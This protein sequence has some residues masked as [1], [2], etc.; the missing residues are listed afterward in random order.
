MLEYQLLGPLEVRRAGEPVVLTAPKVKALL[1]QLLLRADEVVPTEHLVDALWGEEPPESARKLVQVY[2]SQLRVALGTEEIETAAAGYRLRVSSTALDARRF[3]TMREDGAR[4]LADGNPELALA[5]TRRALSLWRGS[6]LAGVAEEA[7]AAAEAWRLEELRLE[8]TEDA[9]DAE[10]ALGRHAEVIPDLRSLSSEHPLRERLRERLALALYRAGRQSEALAVL[11]EGR[12]VLLEELGLAPGRGHQDLERAILAQDPDLDVAP[13]GLSVGHLVPA[14][15]TPLVGRQDEL[16]RLRALID[17]EEVRLVTIS[18][19]GGSGKTRVALELA[20]SATDG[21]A[22]GV[23]FVELAAT[24]DP[25]L[26]LPAIA[27]GLGVPETKEQKPAEALAHWLA[28]RDLLLVV[29]NLEHVIDAAGDL[30]RLLTAAPRLTLLVTS[31][32]VLH[33]SGE[34]VFPLAPLPVDEAVRLFSERAAARDRTVGADPDTREVLVSI[35]RRLD[36]LPLA[37]ELAA[38]RT[39]TLSPTRLLERLAHRVTA[40][41][42]GPRDAPARQRTLEDTLRWSTDLLSGRER[43]ALARLSV[44]SGGSTIEAAE[45][46]SETDLECLAALI[47][48]SLVQRTALGGDVRLSMLET[49]REHAAALLGASGDRDAAEAAHAAYFTAVAEAA[50]G[51]GPLTQAATLERID[52]DLANL[53][54]AMDRAEQRGDD[55][56]ALRIAN[57]LYRYHYVRSSFREGRDRIVGPLERGAGD[58]ALQALAL[59]AVAGFSFMLGDLDAADSWAQRGVGIGTEAGTLDAVL[60]CH[61]VIS[62]VARERGEFAKAR[63]HLL[64]NEAIAHQLGREQDL[65]VANTNLGELA[66][67]VGDLDEA[68]RRWERSMTTFGDDDE[69]STFALLGLGAVAHRQGRLDDAGAHFSR[70]RQLTERAGWLHNLTMALIGLAGVAA[71]RGDHP[72]A[73]ELLGRAEGIR[74][75]TGADLTLADQEVVEQA[76]TASVAALGPVRFAE[77][78]ALGEN[79]ASREMA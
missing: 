36:C 10:L 52:A 43:G 14:A 5:L 22:N 54:T 77:L 73:A 1:V 39:T 69:N 75:A 23:A 17:R 72:G 19:A 50:A 8:C 24:Q 44:F 68:R 64:R 66:L 49:I 42:G 58:P 47:D 55:E 59:R 79:A 2:V 26:V 40:L 78:R 57:A 60:A 37:L 41:G 30:A 13:A 51:T 63:E 46:V 35:C 67:A 61:T 29:D 12:R 38:A 11:A 74:V 21:F 6:A 31:R 28:S 25:T 3:E 70:A 76:Q 18:G 53:R 33:V 56:T 4:A 9:A 32:R 34:H 65:V 16:R 20:R 27:A 7:A 45:A 48:S 62:H 15:T 71:D